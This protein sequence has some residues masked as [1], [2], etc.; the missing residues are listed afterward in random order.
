MSI[1]A[2]TH[3]TTETTARRGAE[4]AHRAPYRVG[5]HVRALFA[6]P[7]RGTCL[8][9]AAPVVAIDRDESRP[10]F[11]WGLTYE[12][13]PGQWAGT[14]VNGSGVDVH[15]YV[16]PSV[17]DLTI[18]EQT[19]PAA[20]FAITLAAQLRQAGVVGPLARRT[21]DGHHIVRVLWPSGRGRLRVLVEAHHGMATFQVETYRDRDT[22]HPDAAREAFTVPHA[23]GVILPALL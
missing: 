23:L 17:T 11:P 6:D 20:Q 10:S 14:H 19:D 8:A 15:R 13:R 4:R 22:P 12:V 16:E 3:P 2:H 1:I 18:W 21:A 9:L 7:A 5:D